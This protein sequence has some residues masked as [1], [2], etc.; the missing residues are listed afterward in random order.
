MLGGSWSSLCNGLHDTLAKPQAVDTGGNPPSEPR[1]QVWGGSPRV[2]SPCCLHVQG[3]LGDGARLCS[4]TPHS[5][6][7]RG[8]KMAARRPAVVPQAR[9]A[10]RL[11]PS[12]KNASAPFGL[13]LG[14]AR[15]LKNNK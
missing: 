10:W 9:R 11:P 12:P 8:D 2:R 7:S 3:R 13:S 5:D 4:P 14:S 6:N 1:E 15:P